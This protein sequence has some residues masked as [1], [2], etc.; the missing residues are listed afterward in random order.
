MAVKKLAILIFLMSCVFRRSIGAPALIYDRILTMA[1]LEN[2]FQQIQK[3]LQNNER[4]DIDTN[5]LTYLKDFVK[6]SA[7]LKIKFRN[8]LVK[9]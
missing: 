3:L 2:T 6:V 5:H 9:T 7:I 1:E 4:S 8:H